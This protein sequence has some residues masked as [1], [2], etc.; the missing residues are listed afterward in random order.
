MSFLSVCLVA[1]KEHEQKRGQSQIELIMKW[2]IE[3]KIVHGSNS[4]IFFLNVSL[5]VSK[6][7]MHKFGHWHIELI[8]IYLMGL[9]ISRGS[10]G[11]MSGHYLFFQRM[12]GS[13]ERTYAKNV[14]NHT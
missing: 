8:M 6:E 4:S 10:Q 1:S 9:M 7:Y 3:Q 13:I 14:A 2:I 11:S 5:V 12:F